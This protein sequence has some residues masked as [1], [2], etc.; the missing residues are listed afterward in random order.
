VTR[1]LRVLVT[2]GCVYYALAV[3][4]ALARAGH[5]VTM[6]DST[7]R[8]AGFFSR[9]ASARWRYP[10]IARDPAA[11]V[12]AVE[13]YL[14]ARPHDVV[15]PLYEE[16]L[17]LSR[18]AGRIT[19]HARLALPDY[20]TM[21]Q[22][23]D[24]ARLYALAA[25]HGVPTPRT[26]LV[27]GEPPAAFAYPAVVKVPQSSCAR[28]VAH[29]AGPGAFRATWSDLARRHQLPP[30]V[31]AILQQRVDGVQHCTLTLAHRGRV[32][33]TLVYRNLAELPPGG[34]AGV[35]RVSVRHLAIE[36]HVE[37][38]VAATGWHGVVGFDFLVERGTGRALLIDGNPRFT[39][40]TLLAERCGL[41]LVGAL[42]EGRERSRARPLRAGV[43]TRVEPLLAL[44]VA[45]MLTP[46]ADL[47]SRLRT[48]GQVLAACA[49]G[50]SDCF[51]VDDPRTFL[52]I[53]AAAI[54]GVAVALGLR[55]ADS[56]VDH[57]CWA[58]YEDPADT[59]R[60]AGQG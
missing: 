24:K 7:P 39:P 10:S 55:S 19:R 17:V 34:G 22:V 20:P 3:C 58:D 32:Q 52:A 29:V 13:R 25:R 51:H 45:R 35:A 60:V 18:D 57:A 38:L 6:A 2:G 47:G 12:D 26:V 36:R 54:D 8:A 16:A 42:V 56:L 48:A 53:P 4:R 21:M 46:G 14:A 40:G 43:V 30:G 11:F 37:A 33:G 31:P 15:L 5:V 44:W 28:G 59:I 9:H 50:A 49:G 23:H 1:P 27:D 41:D